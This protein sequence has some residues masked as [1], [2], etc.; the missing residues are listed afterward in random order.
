MQVVRSRNVRI[1]CNN[2]MKIK[3]FIDY[4]GR[5]EKIYEFKI[6]FAGELPKD[7]KSMLTAT[8]D[9]YSVVEIADATR[10]PITPQPLDFPLEKNTHVNII[11]AKLK[12]PV[13]PQEIEA[14]VCNV[15]CC[16]S[17]K[18]KVFTASQCALEYQYQQGSS[19]CEQQ[20]N[21]IDPQSL[22]GERRISDFLKD[23]EKEAKSRILP[24]D[25]S[26]ASTTSGK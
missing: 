16:T 20:K 19:D 14:L 24:V 13:T 26:A 10:T 9:K 23:L 11:C 12:Y 3:S 18:C 7:Y 17:S 8:L 22:V 5:S 4:L 2:M 15:F 6:K 21:N 1:A 25:S